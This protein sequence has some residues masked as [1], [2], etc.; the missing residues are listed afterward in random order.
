MVSQRLLSRPIRLATKAVRNGQSSAQASRA[1]ATSTCRRKELAVDTSGMP[2][3]RHAP[4]GT[5]GKLE[6]P[7]VNPAGMIDL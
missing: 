7:I 2:D 1:F 3:M 6:A 5:I 4:R